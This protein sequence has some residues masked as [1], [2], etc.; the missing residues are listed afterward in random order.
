VAN[1]DSLAALLR[2]RMQAQ[3]DMFAAVTSHPT[4]IGSGREEALAEL[5]RQLL[6]RRLELLSGTIAI[7]DAEGI[8]ERSTHQIDL[9]IADTLDYPTLLRVGGIAVVLPPAVRALIEVKSD[10]RSCADFVRGIAQSCRIKQQLGASEP[11]FTTLFS[12]AAPSWNSTPASLD[13]GSHA[14]PSQSARGGSAGCED[15][16][17][18]GARR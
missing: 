7:F 16:A 8:P 17:R 4:L 10:L 13:R 6:P 9:I 18:R 2:R 11:V 5:L 1:D 12:F 14:A 3:A 15:A